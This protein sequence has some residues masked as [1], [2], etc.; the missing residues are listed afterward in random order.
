MGYLF[1]I[2][3]CFLEIFVRDK[4]VMEVDKVTIEGSATDFHAALWNVTELIVN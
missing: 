1:T 3:Y 2:G 4:A